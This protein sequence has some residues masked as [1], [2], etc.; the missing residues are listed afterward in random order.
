MTKFNR[1]NYLKL[2][3]DRDLISNNFSKYKFKYPTSIY[4][5]IGSDV[6]RPDIISYKLFGRIDYW[7]FIMKL[8]K[9]DDVWNELYPGLILRVPDIR[10]IN[11]Y[12]NTFNQE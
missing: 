8:N 9:I 11:D 7:W 4:K 5:V 3:T 12:T 2:N 1:D 6:Q 10:D